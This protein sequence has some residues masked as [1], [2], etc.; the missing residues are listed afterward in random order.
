MKKDI[1]YRDIFSLKNK[2]TIILGGAGLI[3]KEISL[4]YSIYG[5]KVVILDNNINKAKEIVKTINSKGYDAEFLFFDSNNSNHIKNKFN[6]ILKNLKKIDV[7][8]NCSYPHTKDW[9]YN[10]F[11][12]IKLDSLKKNIECHLI[13]YS[14]LSRSVANYMV[15]KKINGSIINLASIYGLVGQNL[16]VYKDTQM[17]ENMTYSII[18]GGIINLTRQMASYYGQYNI[19]IN[20]ISPGGLLGHVVGR[21][22]KQ[23]KKFIKQYSKLVPLKRLGNPSEI[24]GVS[25]LLGSNASTYITGSNLIVDGGWVSI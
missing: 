11:K 21:G 1:N 20:S 3:G 6:D 24:V 17:N 10:S 14:W 9:A 13:S 2:T 22:K 4:A 8:I 23:N 12:K 5:S 19:R 7:F 16:N 25:L 18:K 15:T